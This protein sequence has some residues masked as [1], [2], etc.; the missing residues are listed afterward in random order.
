MMFVTL[1]VIT[2]LGLDE[3]G[4]VVKMGDY[5]QSF[6]F[7]F[8]SKMGNSEFKTLF[9]RITVAKVVIKGV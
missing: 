1:R 4:L 7:V 6:S 2:E 9:P 3:N 5:D 8:K